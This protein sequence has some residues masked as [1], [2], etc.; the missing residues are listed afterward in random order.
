[1][2][3]V[4]NG[5]GGDKLSKGPLDQAVGRERAAE[6]DRGTREQGRRT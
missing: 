6:W 5:G 3:A 2:E 4:V 1:M